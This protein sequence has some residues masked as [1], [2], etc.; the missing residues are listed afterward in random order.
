MSLRSSAESLRKGKGLLSGVF[1]AWGGVESD[2]LMLGFVGV[3]RVL[4]L[5]EQAG[6]IVVARW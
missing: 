1:F 4:P 5:D 2:V 6:S 3:V